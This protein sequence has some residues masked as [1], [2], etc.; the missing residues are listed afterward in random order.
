MQMEVPPQANFLLY[1][2][3]PLL[4]LNKIFAAAQILGLGAPE[5][6]HTIDDV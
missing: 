5:V 3:I 2:C 1:E 4:H 6:K